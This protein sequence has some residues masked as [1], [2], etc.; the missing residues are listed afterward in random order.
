METDSRTALSALD[1]FGIETLMCLRDLRPSVCE[2][3]SSPSAQAAIQRRPHRCD[4]ACWG[5][6]K[7]ASGVV[8]GAAYVCRGRDYQS[9]GCDRGIDRRIPGANTARERKYHRVRRCQ[10]APRVGTVQE[11]G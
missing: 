6:E 10:Q 8:A 7:I 2:I 9:S 11:A 3:G 1:E 4:I 5:K